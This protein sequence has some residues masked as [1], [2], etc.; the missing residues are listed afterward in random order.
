[1]ANKLMRLNEVIE[2]TGLDK[3]YI[4]KCVEAGSLPVIKP[5]QGARNLYKREDVKRVFNLD[6]D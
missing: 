6:L 4:L 5:Y 3:Q 2:L 1:M